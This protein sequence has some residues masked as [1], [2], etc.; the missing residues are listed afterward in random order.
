ITVKTRAEGNRVRVSIADPGVGIPSE[1]LKKIFDPGFTT[2]GVGVG[3]GLSLSIVYNVVEEHGGEIDVES[4][5]DKGT[6]FH[7]YLPTTAGG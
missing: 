5:V 7:L 3:T 4:R 1:N 2:K 6:T